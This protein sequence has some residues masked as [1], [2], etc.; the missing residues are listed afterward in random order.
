MAV[1]YLAYAKTGKEFEVEDE[2]RALDIPVWC[3]RVIECKRSGKR[4]KAEYHEMP[5]LPNYLFAELTPTTFYEAIAVKH[6]YPFLYAL[7]ESDRRNLASFK[8]E[9]DADYAEADRAR[10]RGERIVAEYAPGD[11]IMAVQGPFRDVLLRF[12]RVIEN[13]EPIT[14][15]AE[16][17][18]FGRVTRVHVDPLDLRRA[19]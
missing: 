18:L 11:A 16:M 12:R 6:L 5:K 14:Y 15:E 2:L 19:V 4:R 3:A 13:S 8:R 7:G 10:R 9:V 1:T 17:Q